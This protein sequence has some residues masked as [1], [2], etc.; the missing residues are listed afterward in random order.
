MN[1][2]TEEDISL[3]SSK[4]ISTE[5]IHTQIGNFRKGFPFSDLVKPATPGD[6]IE[7]LTDAETASLVTYYEQDIKEKKIIKFVPASGAASR[8][9]KVL[10][11]FM[12]LSDANDQ[13]SRFENDKGFNSPWNFISCINK[14]AFYDD[15]KAVISAKALQL[16]EEVEKK[17]HHTVIDFLVSD[18]GLDYGNLPKGLLKFH[19]YNTSNR[20]S[21]EEHLVEAA[22]YATSGNR[23]AFVHFTVSAEHLDKFKTKVSEVKGD[24]EDK[25]KI[26]YNISFSVQKPS[27]DTIAVDMQNN[28]F[29]EPDGTILFRPGGHGALIENLGD[30]HGDIIFIK[31]IDNV[32]PDR[33]KKETT[34]YKKA[35]GGL[36]LKLQAGAFE[37]L[38]IL[39]QGVSDGDSLQQIAEFA[40]RDLKIAL[41]DDF[42]TFSTGRKTDFF[43]HILNRPVRVCGMVKNEGEP[44][45]GPFWIRNSRG[46]VSLQ[47]VESSQINLNDPEQLKHLQAATHFNPVDLVCATRLSG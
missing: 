5:T 6:G 43:R 32:V 26:T 44:G 1:K 45:G 34:I 12:E 16:E 39:D 37:Y 25:F 21:L 14:F 36:L 40:T 28:P 22:R 46:H 18:K 17:R 8:M 4:E 10:F 27:T 15:L 35:I 41:P 13:L 19:A 31:N 3:F 29:R 20:V 7:V 2:F 24:Y 42:N 30:M 38:R 11:E 33:I 23:I 9:F 47:I